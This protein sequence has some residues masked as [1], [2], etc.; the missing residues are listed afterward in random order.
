MSLGF[1][2]NT[3]ELADIELRSDSRHLH[4]H[5]ARASQRASLLGC[6]GGASAMPMSGPIQP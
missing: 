1:Y 5:T 2:G 4:S 3:P 6:Y